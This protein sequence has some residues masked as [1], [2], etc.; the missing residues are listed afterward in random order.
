MQVNLSVVEIYC[1]RIRD[2]LSDEA[3]S[4]KLVVQQDRQR[5]VYIAGATQV[6]L[7]IALHQV[8]TRVWVPYSSDIR[9]P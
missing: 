3:G 1:E 5:G 4:D 7:C 8:L 9:F 6:T 2:L